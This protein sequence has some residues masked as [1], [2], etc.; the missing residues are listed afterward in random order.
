MSEEA[1]QAVNPAPESSTPV[2]DVKP[3]AEEGVK[4]EE[5]VKDDAKA[6][7]GEAKE[8]PKAEL[9]EAEKTRIAMQK[10]IDRQTAANKAKDEQLRQALAEL[11]QLKA[12]APKAS[13]E[14]KSEDFNSY[15]EYENARVEWLANKKAEE[16]IVAEKERQ[17]QE[18]N[19]RRAAEIK[20]EMDA[21]E[22]ILRQ[23]IPDFD[24]AAQQAVQTMKEL[25]DVGVNVGMLQGM[26]MHFDNPPELIYQLGKDP[27]LIEELASM[28]PL[29]AMKEL[30]K[31]EMAQQNK[32]K[33]QPKA[34]PEPIKPVNPNGRA[35]KSIE[36]MTYEEREE[37]YKRK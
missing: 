4:P 22:E 19:Q 30:V 28:P 26:V 34:P 31:L 17:V 20:K 32:P 25:G 18:A 3:K 10:R 16:R 36:D 1:L 15:E 8:E 27:S 21:K 13:D 6:T 37:Y 9:S 14:P 11:E 7:D 29:K 23:T 35:K 24:E 33:D 2:E 12:N 5:A